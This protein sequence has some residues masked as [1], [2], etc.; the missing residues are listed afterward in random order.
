M[1]ITTLSEAMG[2]TLGGIPRAGIAKEQKVELASFEQLVR[3]TIVS[4]AM[5]EHSIRACVY[6]CRACFIDYDL[7]LLL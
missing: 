3:T 5:G 1:G 6:V 7:N 2:S 4:E